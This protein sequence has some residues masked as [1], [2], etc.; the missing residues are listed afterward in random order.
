LR[1][2]IA[3]FVVIAGVVAL[4]RT[5]SDGP[6]LVALDAS[7]LVPLFLSASPAAL[8]PLQAR[9]AARWLERAFRNLASNAT[10]GT[11]LRVSPWARVGADSSHFDE[12]RLL[13]LPRVAMPGVLGLEVG[14]GWGS[15][16][17]GPSASPEI[18]ARVLEESPAAARLA[19]ELPKLRALPGR[20]PEER[21]VR[22]LPRLPTHACTVALVRALAEALTDRRTAAAAAPFA[23]QE[24][25]RTF[26]PAEKGADGG[27]LAAAAV[28]E[29]AA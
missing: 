7:I 2:A 12:L 28:G 27:D 10:L 9:T 14:L 8:M 15:T 11:R 6:W 26:V 18:L 3:V 1:V 24:R 19:V 23:A 29:A 25:R 16:P 4:A 21:V 20:R 22:M 17:A 5:H 13:V